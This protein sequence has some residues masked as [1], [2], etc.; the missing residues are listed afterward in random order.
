ML[1]PFVLNPFFE[2]AGLFLPNLLLL[3]VEGVQLDF[4]SLTPVLIKF[5]AR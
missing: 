1:L 3:L 4:L 2:L 5:A